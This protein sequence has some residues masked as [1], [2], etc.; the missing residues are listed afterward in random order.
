[1]ATSAAEKP[2]PLPLGTPVSAT[3]PSE[4]RSP[5]AGTP[6][7]IKL[8]DGSQK[9]PIT[10]PAAYLDFLKTL[11]PALM[12]P[13]SATRMDFPQRPTT[14][15]SKGSSETVHTLASDAS[16]AAPTP[17]LS[18]VNTAETAPSVPGSAKESKSSSR[19]SSC[20]SRRDSAQEASNANPP[21]STKT[22]PNMKIAIPP[23]SPFQRPPS[24]RTPRRLHI[25]P[26]P[27]SAGVR[28]PMS[29][30]SVTGM[31]SPYSATMSPLEGELKSPYT[32]GPSKPVNVS[33][34]QVVT[35]TVMYSAA[36]PTNPTP[37]VEPV[38]PSKKRKIE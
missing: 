21:S 36:R 17:P 18:R 24:A 27:R 22:E 23:P 7:F 10:P 1:M 37:V 14:L 12:S 31:Y 5:M 13:Q 38:P 4:L 35:R 15:T 28:S 26:S 34:R 9:T 3:Y 2:H 6:T 8:E 25:P 16:D 32:T 30:H 11:S 19:S 20:S 33:V 29:A